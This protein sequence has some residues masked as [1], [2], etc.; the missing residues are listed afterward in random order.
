VKRPTIPFADWRLAVDLDATRLI[1]SLPGREAVDCACIWCRNWSAV[2]QRALPA[3]VRQQLARLGADA[4]R[5]SDSY[6]FREDPLE[7]RLLYHCVGRILSGPVSRV[8]FK[9][10]GDAETDPPVSGANFTRIG[11]PPSQV[12]AIVWYEK[13]AHHG[14]QQR[15]ATEAVEPLVRIDLLAV[16]PWALSEPMPRRAST[17]PVRSRRR[18]HARGGAS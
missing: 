15:W 7:Y 3:S 10:P 14:P 8:E 4:A 17:E 1:E 13:E 12:G 6:P 11:D 16:A 5:P 2:Y 18:S 9:L